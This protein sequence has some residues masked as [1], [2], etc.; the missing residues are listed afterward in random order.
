MERRTKRNNKKRGGINY[1]NHKNFRE[2]E[3]KSNNKKRGGI[4]YDS[5]KNLRKKY[6]R[7][8]Q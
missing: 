2:K 6:T 4:N 7:R 8:Q 1:D 3:Q 5:R